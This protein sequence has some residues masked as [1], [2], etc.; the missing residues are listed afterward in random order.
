M[1]KSWTLKRKYYIVGI[2]YYNNNY[3]S[4]KFTVLFLSIVYYKLFTY[5][6]YLVVNSLEW[7]TTKQL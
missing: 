1:V 6:K 5:Y 2:R 4:R 7:S 3:S